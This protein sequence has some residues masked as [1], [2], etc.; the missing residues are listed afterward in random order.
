M[1]YLSDETLDPLEEYNLED[2]DPE[3]FS[4]EDTEKIIDSFFNRN[5]TRYSDTFSCEECGSQKFE[6]IVPRARL[7]F[8]IIDDGSVE[9][10]QDSLRIEAFNEECFTIQCSDC[11]HRETKTALELGF[12]QD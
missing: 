1:R 2:I 3:D 7:P 4:I 5:L 11:Q 9:I 10:E 8:S 12:V 6:L